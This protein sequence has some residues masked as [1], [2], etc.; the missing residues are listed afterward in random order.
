[1][2]C[3]QNPCRHW[4]DL[5]SWYTVTDT[6]PTQYSV[7]NINCIS[8][9]SITAPSQELWSAA[10]SFSVQN[11][12]SW[13]LITCAD[14]ILNCKANNNPVSLCQTQASCLSNRG[15]SWLF[16]P[17]AEAGGKN[18]TSVTGRGGGCHLCFLF[19]LSRYGWTLWVVAA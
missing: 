9:S 6:F 12:L 19:M 15:I 10:L 11:N 5:T 7:Y 13:V 18:D 3:K 16:F 14:P 2:V 4:P 17:M 1:M 8:N